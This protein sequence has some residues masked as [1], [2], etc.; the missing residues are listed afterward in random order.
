MS[1]SLDLFKSIGAPYPASLL[2][3][4]SSILFLFLLNLVLTAVTIHSQEYY[5]TVSG[6]PG[7]DGRDGV[8]GKDGIPGS[9]GIPGPPGEFLYSELTSASSSIKTQ[10]QAWLDDQ[11]SQST[12]SST[13]SQ[14]LGWNSTTPATSCLHI[15]RCDCTSPSGMYWISEGSSGATLS[16]VYCDMETWHCGSK[17]W[18]R[19]AYIDMR[20]PGATCPDSLR[21]ITSPRNFCAR[22]DTGGGSCS[23]VT[24]PTL[25]LKYNKVCGQAVGYQRASADGFAGPDSIDSQYTDGVSITYGSPRKHIWTYCVGI[26]DDQAGGPTCPCA[27]TPG[28]SPPPFVGNDYYCESGNVGGWENVLYIDDTLWDG[29]G[30]GDGNNCC[31]QPGM[32]W[33]CR[34]LPQMVGED[35]EVRLCADQG[36]SDEDIYLEL[37]EIYVQ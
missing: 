14:Y 34:T 36:P 3:M 28:P 37:L 17:G 20:Q 19:V 33:F 29:D 21:Q 1:V 23:S 18:T 10:A 8:P 16:Q 15:Y 24:F 5:A 25:G 12:A 9:N 22:V 2:S 6:K 7:R 32:P 11:L 30:C 31:A 27:K 4:M 13:C 35:I 26:S